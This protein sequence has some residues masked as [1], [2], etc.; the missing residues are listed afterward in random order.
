MRQHQNFEANHVFYMFSKCDA[1]TNTQTPSAGLMDSAPMH[2][3]RDKIILAIRTD[4]LRLRGQS[5][6]FACAAVNLTRHS[7]IATFQLPQVIYTS[8]P[9]AS[10]I[11]SPFN[12][13]FAYVASDNGLLR[14]YMTPPLSPSTPLQ[15]S[16]QNI[17]KPSQLNMAST[18]QRKKAGDQTC[19]AS[20]PVSQQHNQTAPVAPTTHTLSQR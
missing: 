19:P 2:T 4:R 17:N 7:L 5:S 14:R 20:Q 9:S 13:S 6:W 11:S 15:A 18:S 1:H 8:Y 16:S 3:V 12:L 10:E